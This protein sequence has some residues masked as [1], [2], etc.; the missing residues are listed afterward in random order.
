[1]SVLKETFSATGEHEGTCTS[2][3]GTGK[4]ALAELNLRGCREGGK[5]NWGG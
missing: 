2:A 3:W 1:M 4:E 5:G